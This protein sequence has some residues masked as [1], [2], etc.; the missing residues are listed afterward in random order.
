MVCVLMPFYGRLSVEFIAFVF[1]VNA[2]SLRHYHVDCRARF[3]FLPN[4]YLKRRK[5][6]GDYA[7]IIQGAFLTKL[8]FNLIKFHFHSNSLS[9]HFLFLYS[10]PLF[11]RSSF[12]TVRVVVSRFMNVLVASQPERCPFKFKHNSNTN[13]KNGYDKTVAID[14]QN[15]KL[16]GEGRWPIHSHSF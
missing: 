5:N 4:A 2:F 11:A 7:S 15:G 13:E 6:V 9:R 16:S 12:S 10:R 3:W 8:I 1:C 14:F